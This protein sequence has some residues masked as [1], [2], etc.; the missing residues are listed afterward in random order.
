[1]TDKFRFL[2]FNT[3]ILFIS[4]SAV[5][6]RYITL[7]STHATWWRCILAAIC[8]FVF[9]Q[10]LRR[11]IHF[12]WRRHGA[13]LILTSLMMAAH[14]TSYFY[15]LDYSNVSIALM[16]L[17]TF[18]A[19]TA[20]LEP[21]FWKTKMKRRDLLLAV[22]S[23]IAVGIIAPPFQISGEVKLAVLLGLFSSI[24]YSLRNIVI[25]RITP[26]YSGTTIMMYQM[27]WMTLF[28]TIPLFWIPM[29]WGQIDWPA[30]LILGIITTAMGHTLFMRGLA[31]Y[32]ATTASLMA[33][34]VPVYA[35]VL[36]YLI[37]GEVPSL[38]SII[39]GS[40]IFSVVVLKAL[41]K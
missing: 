1:M 25:T 16:T 29:D 28:L 33:C 9:Q 36:A 10:L 23:L 32:K 6:G 41:E 11:N 26:Y 14:W 38:R 31:F 27:F 3:G 7:D 5:L 40:I 18:P 20:I 39:G 2:E 37:I 22:I 4:S 24:L 21:L 30:I 12:D 15:A 17:Y 34:S 35:V 19:F 13:I 8:L